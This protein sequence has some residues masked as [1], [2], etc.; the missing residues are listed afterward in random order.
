[1]CDANAFLVDTVAEAGASMGAD[2]HMVRFQGLFGKRHGSEG[3]DFIR[4]A[5]DDT[6]RRARPNIAREHFRPAQG[7]GNG[8][9]PGERFFAAW[10]GVERH[11]GALT[12][13]DKGD[14]FR[15]K[16]ENA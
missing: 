1:M 14:I 5:V 12:E 3:H 13:A 2:G 7:A 4:R 6:D 9:D 8:D 11:H 10:G 16:F 15:R